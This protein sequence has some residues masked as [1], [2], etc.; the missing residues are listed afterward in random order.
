MVDEADVTVH[1]PHVATPTATLS[2]ALAGADAVVVAAN[3]ADFREAATLAAIAELAGG[4]CLV[5]DPWDCWGAA[6]VFGYAGE[7]AQ[8]SPP[9]G[10]G[11]G[12]PE[13][14]PAPEREGQTR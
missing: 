11:A 4:N 12:A 14:E 5:V 13:R 3:H 8:L 1:D 6:Q 9:A 2:E 10:S 7:L